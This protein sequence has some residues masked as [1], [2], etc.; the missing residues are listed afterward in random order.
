M[1]YFE[2]QKAAMAIF[3]MLWTFIRACPFCEILDNVAYLGLKLL[4][5]PNHLRNLREG[6]HFL[7]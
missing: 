1:A 3:I 5:K 2:K 6:N 7:V 4:F